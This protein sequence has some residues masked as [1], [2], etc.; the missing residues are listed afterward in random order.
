MIGSISYLISVIDASET[1]LGKVFNVLMNMKFK[2]IL[3]D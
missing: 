3:V 2:T 1:M